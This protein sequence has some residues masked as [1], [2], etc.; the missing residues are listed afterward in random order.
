M[1]KQTK[2]RAFYVAAGLVVAYVAAP[3]FMAGSVESMV[4]STLTSELDTRYPGLVLLEYD[5]GWFKSTATIGVKAPNM[6]PEDML[7]IGLKL[8]C[9]T[10]EVAICFDVDIKHGPIV[11][12][13]GKPTLAVGQV[14][15]SLSVPFIPTST[16]ETEVIKQLLSPWALSVSIT[17]HFDETIDYEVSTSGVDIDLEEGGAVVRVQADP[18]QLKGSY[19]IAE[20]TV[21]SQF[22]LTKLHAEIVEDGR[23]K[24]NVKIDDFY[25]SGKGTLIGHAFAY[26][27]TELSIANIQVQ[28]DERGNDA[29]V[30]LQNFKLTSTISPEG[31]SIQNLITMGLEKLYVNEGHENGEKV[32]V[33]N[34]N[35][36]A[37]VHGVDRPMYE[38]LLILANTITPG[39]LMRDQML[40]VSDHFHDLV[41]KGLNVDVNNFSVNINDGKLAY[42]HTLNMPA[43]V[44][45][46]DHDAF[47][48]NAKLEGTVTLDQ[49]LVDFMKAQK[50]RHGRHDDDDDRDDTDF[51]TAVEEGLFVKEGD[52]YVAKFSLTDG[53]GTINGKNIEDF[54]GKIRFNRDRK[55]DKENDLD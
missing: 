33:T 39:D 50:A 8:L 25:A 45:W 10:D 7:K 44:D 34:L 32:N 47:K 22:S 29:L 40:Q 49:K 17:A 26:G 28:S 19:S 20:G 30:D 41:E 54:K 53:V 27:K 2:R 18:I 23:E 16:R 35:F 1:K 37:L 24:V 48:N 43:G 11:S 46:E 51:D 36:E 13:F 42:N 55:K 14:Q 12:S 9:G 21:F 31:E 15:T 52:N 3:G 5:R 6:N 4:K 38:S